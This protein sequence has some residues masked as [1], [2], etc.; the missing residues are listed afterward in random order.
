VKRGAFLLILTALAIGVL[1]YQVS[2]AAQAQPQ[3]PKEEELSIHRNLGKAFYENPTT[4]AQAVEE[5]KKALDLAPESARERLNYGLSLLRDGKTKEGVAELE[6]VQQRDPKLPH[7]WF[8][9][10]IAFKQQSD[11]DHAI[12]QFEQMVKLVPNEPVSHYNLGYLY[13]LAAKQDLALKSFET[14]AKLD[15]GLAGPHFQLYNAYR[16]AGRTEDANRELKLFQEI[17]KLQ[18]GAVI[19]EDLDWSGYAEVYDPVEPSSAKDEPKPAELK[20]DDK[21]IADGFDAKTAGMAVL[22]YDGDGRPDL[23]AWSSA[24]VRIFKNGS[25][26]VQDTGLNDLKGVVSITPGDFNNDGLPD[27][28][29]I[30]ESGASLYINDKGA[31]KKSPVQLLPGKYAKAVWLD[32]DHDYDLDLFLLGEKSVLMRNNGTSGF[33]NETASFPFVAGKVLDAVVTDLDAYGN[34]MDLVVSYT[35]HGAVI[36]RDKLEGKYEAEPTSNV[37]N[38]RSLIARDADGDGWTDLLSMGEGGYSWWTNRNGLLVE[39]LHDS[40]YPESNPPMLA[41]FDNGEHIQVVQ[42]GLVY[43]VERKGLL[44][45]RSPIFSDKAPAALAASDF[46]GD[47]KTDLAAIYSDGSL[48]LLRN[49]TET[50]NK[51]IEVSLTGIKNLKLAPG[52]RVEVKAGSHYEK[53]TYAGVPLVFGLGLHTEADTVR[54]TW[55]NGLVQNEMKV[56]ANKSITIKEAQRLSGSCPMIFTWNGKNFEF[57]TDVLGVAP[58]GASSGDGEFFSVDHQEYIQIPGSSLAPK[59]GRY[60][61]RIT[62]ELKEVSYIDAVHLM[63]VDHPAGLE[64][65]TN[66]KFKS[67]PFPDHRLFGVKRRIYP[68]AAQDDRGRDVLPQL[69]R[70]DGQYPDAFARDYSGVAEKH[71]LDLDFGN[72]APDNRAVL[73]LNGWLDWA[74]G[75]TYRAVSQERKGGLLM[76]YLQV[77]DSQ[78]RW[79]TV[80]GDMGIPAGKPKTIVVDLTGKFLSASRQVRIVTDLCLYWDEIFLGEENSPPEA[81]VN[82]LETDSADL[83]F[84]GFSK[85]TIHPQRKQPESFDYQ[86]WMAFTMWNPTPGYYTRYGDVKTLLESADD[87]LVLMGSGDEMRLLFSP[88]NLPALRPGWRR[89]FLLLVDGWAKDQDANTAYS[90]SVEPLPFHGMSGYPYPGTEHFPDDAAHRQYQKQYN[91]RPALRLLRPLTEYISERR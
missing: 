25:V 35:D 71:S 77:K 83:S 52:A 86:N 32:Y 70:R 87:Q 9:L 80:I 20:F 33:S 85:P 16:A 17:K 55:P 31:F 79:Q 12:Q 81:A 91:T 76:P 84:R 11:Y 13:K 18:A 89:D 19:P 65:F 54:I 66:E 4:H 57:I 78:G 14:A 64:I 46:D 28:C 43:Q 56:A 39:P 51:W 74:D 88:S 6:K 10:G 8:N 38:E 36:Y 61:V 69:L 72:A 59:D 48:H 26:A 15:P 58:L 53:Q 2:G 1:R 37:S 68:V 40:F 45:A 50:Q 49:Q 75:S 63:A 41:N 60:E 21:K 27:L 67:P 23:I 34:G 3:T 90:Q 82:T 29:V 42:H 5:F 44:K 47:G 30:T 22:D 24:G 7:T 73:V 62:E